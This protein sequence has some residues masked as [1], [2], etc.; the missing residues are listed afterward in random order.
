[1]RGIIG[2]AA[3][4]SLVGGLIGAFAVSELS[5]QAGAA[6]PL[7]QAREDQITIF[8]EAGGAQQGSAGSANT[9]DG[10]EFGGLLNTGPV[11]VALDG[12]EYPTSSSFHLEVLM[13]NGAQGTFC[14]RLFNITTNAPASGSEVCF[15]AVEPESRRLRSGLLTLPPG[16]HVYTVQGKADSPIGARAAVYAA[17]II[18]EW[19]E[20]AR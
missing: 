4:L 9:P 15:T 5:D 10:P 3:V 11:L 6:P 18:A 2:L 7:P 17:R 12:A 19:T 14:A 8:S 16:E 1:M 13:A 20:R